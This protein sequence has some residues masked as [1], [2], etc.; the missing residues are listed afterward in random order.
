MDITVEVRGI[1]LFHGDDGRAPFRNLAFGDLYLPEMQAHL[2]GIKLI[3]HPARGY[4][5]R[6]SGL[7]PGQ[8]PMITWKH[9]GPLGKAVA[10]ALAAAYVRMTG[11][12]P[13]AVRRAPSEPKRLFIPL[14]ELDMG[15][16]PEDLPRPERIRLALEDESE[17]RGVECFTEVFDS[18]QRD[19]ADHEV[20]AGL[21]RFIGADLAAREACDEAGL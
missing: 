3:W 21:R 20:D 5:T 13:E 1:S 8:D 12:D 16:I 19:A 17:V 14:H 2:K 6:V 4:E 11:D 18:T 10:T 9:R 7:R 15:G